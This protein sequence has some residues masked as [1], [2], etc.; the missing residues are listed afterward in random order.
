MNASMPLTPDARE[1]LSLLAYVYL[2]NNRPEKS[3]VLLNALRTLGLADN[4]QLAT[5]ALAQ[6]RAGKS[7]A[8][9]ATLDL[10]AMQGGIDASFHLIRSQALLALERR[11]EAA[12]A[13]RAYVALRP[14]PA[15]APT[16]AETT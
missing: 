4:R 10:L 11:D 12:A 1:L 13:M 14:A 3:A 5:L 7:E 6:L 16:E 8:A 2:E 15:A 9:L